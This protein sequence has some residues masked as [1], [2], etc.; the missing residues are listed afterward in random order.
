MSYPKIVFVGD[1]GVGK[2][3][4]LHTLSTNE[5]D[6]RYC[7]TS[8]A[9]VHPMEFDG[10]PVN[11]WDVGGQDKYV[12]SRE[13]YYAN[14]DAVAIM[15]DVTHKRRYLNV[16]KWY[17][18][19]FDGMPDLPV[20][21]IGNKSD[22]TENRKITEITSFLPYFEVSVKDNQNLSQPFE[23]LTEQITE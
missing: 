3:A 18:D 11:V 13:G 1:G 20:V 23:W 2:T 5:F 8:G 21:L 12:N 6:K 14:A 4:L 9:E 10:S 16:E 17:N 15:F 19:V 22:D 7:A